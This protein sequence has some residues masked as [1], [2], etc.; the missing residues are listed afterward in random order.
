[1][2]LL[3]PDLFPQHQ[4]GGDVAA[5]YNALQKNALDNARKQIEGQYYG[6]KTEAQIASQLTYANLMGPQFAAKLMGNPDIFPNLTDEE[7]RTK[8]NALFNVAQGGGGNALNNPP[9]STGAPIPGKQGK[10]YEGTGADSGYSYDAKGRNI[11]APPELVTAKTTQ[12]P[13]VA[14]TVGG[15]QGT[16]EELKELGKIRAKN[17]EELNNIVFDSDTKLATLNDLNNMVSS[18]EIREIRQLPLAGRHEIAWYAREGTPAQQQLIGRLYTQMGDIVKNS[19]RDFAGQFRKGE[20]QLLQGMKPN[21]SDTVDVMIGKLESL[22]TMSKL[23]RERAALTSQYMGK[24]HIDKLQ[25]SQRADKEINGEKI[26]EQIHD[27]LN[28]TITVR[29]KKTGEIKTIPIA[30]ARKLGVSNV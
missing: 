27:K 13:T 10:T 19:S 18:P 6:P 28:P 26:R 12:Q 14:E 21:D 9:P 29:N 8:I 1:M 7:K 30:E 25:A 11:V 2:A 5:S 24:H 17:I 20:Q 15:Y 23:L 22:T 16:K 4:Y 3:F